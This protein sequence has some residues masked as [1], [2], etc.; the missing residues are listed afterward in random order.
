[1]TI[2]LYRHWEEPQMPPSCHDRLVKVL[3]IEKPVEARLVHLRLGSMTAAPGS[4][5]ESEPHRIHLF[6]PQNPAWRPPPERTRDP[7]DP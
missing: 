7:R 2:K 5:L 3:E 6:R 4:I 1:M